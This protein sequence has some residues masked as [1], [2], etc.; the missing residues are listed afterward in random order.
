MKSRALTCVAAMTLFA[1]L[2][3]P[4]RVWATPEMSFRAERS[5]SATLR[6]NCARNLALSLVWEKPS[7][8]DP[9][10]PSG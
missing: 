3:I 8:Q 4:L 2:A 7:E 6:V 10:L 5:P 9:S 1:A